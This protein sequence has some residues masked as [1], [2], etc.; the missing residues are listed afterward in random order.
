MYGLGLVRDRVR[1]RGPRR[2]ALIAGFALGG[3]VAVAVILATANHAASSTAHGAPLLGVSC[4]SNALCIA[5]DQAGALVSSTRPGRLETWRPSHLG[6]RLTG[7]SCPTS[8]LCVGVDGAGRVLSSSDPSAGAGTWSLPAQIEPA[9]ALGPQP[10]RAVSCP[11]AGLCVAEDGVNV[12]TSRNPAGGSTAWSPPVAIPSHDLINGITCPSASLCI[13][14]DGAGNII[15]ST[16]PTAGAASWSATPVDPPQNGGIYG[17]SC[18]GSLCVA[19]DLSGHLMATTDPAGGQGAWS[20]PVELDRSGFITGAVDCPSRDLCVAVDA[21]GRVIAS[22]NPAGGVATWSAP[23]TLDRGHHLT[24]LSCPQARLC[25]AVDDAGQVFASQRPAAGSDAWSAAGANTGH[26]IASPA[27]LTFPARAVA[28]PSPLLTLTLG[29]RG[30]MSLRAGSISLRGPAARAFSVVADRCR[31]AKTVPAGGCS[32]TLRFTPAGAG[33]AVARLQIAAG[34]PAGPLSVPLRGAGVPAGLPAPSLIWSDRAPAGGSLASLARAGLDGS[35]LTQAFVGTPPPPGAV[36]QDAQHIYWIHDGSIARAN[37]NGT[38]V[39]PNFITGVR[40]YQLALGQQHIFWLGGHGSLGRADLHGNHV[41]TS[42]LDLFSPVGHVPP[43]YLVVT[44]GFVYWGYHHT[45]AVSNLLPIGRARVTGTKV[46]FSFLRPV[47]PSCNNSDSPRLAGV[48]CDLG[49]LAVSGPYLFWGWSRV[50]PSLG[51]AGSGIGR[52]RV[53]GTAIDNQFLATTAPAS[54]AMALTASA[55]NLYWTSEAG[56]A[57]V[58]QDGAGLVDPFITDP[59]ASGY[60]LA[61]APPGAQVLTTAPVD[62]AND[63]P[64]VGS[65]AAVAFSVAMNQRTTSRAFSLIDDVTGRPVPGHVTFAAPGVPVFRP[66]VFYLPPGHIFSARLISTATDATGVPLAN[67]VVW[68]FRVSANPITVSLYPLPGTT[69]ASSA[70][71]VM[72]AFSQPMDEQ[73]TGAAFS[74]VGPDAKPVQG[75]V[76]WHGDAA[77]VFTPAAPLPGHVRYTARVAVSARDG[78]GRPLAGPATWSFTTG[79]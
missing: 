47:V 4:A 72:V 45:G 74:L 57:R 2:G 31:A 66:D 11:S 50:L 28:S 52:A 6:D 15:T 24:G 59:L 25:V 35:A 8:G 40:A 29:V 7:L 71:P 51:A 44:G 34:D 23:A 75:R 37:L 30:R 68:S 33:P 49:G 46:N 73:A 64:A 14:F 78:A 27:A 17:V 9:A 26:L 79:R 22:S 38:D 56:I 67:P 58:N 19:V 60:G 76:S 69:N 3:I 48:A 16:D 1:R 32:I 41:E 70:R 55:S 77:L 36:A 12:L 21:A 54:G 20:A 53:D 65:A 13:A 5:Y 62:G 18:A 63:V 39:Q 43:T 61:V 10:L 42:M